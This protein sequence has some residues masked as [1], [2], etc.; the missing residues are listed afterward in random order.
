MSRGW[1][2]EVVGMVDVVWLLL[3][4]LVVAVVVCVEPGGKD[5]AA[6][7]VTGLENGNLDVVRGGEEFLSGGEPGDAGA[8]DDGVATR[9]GALGVGHGG[10]VDGGG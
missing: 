9:P 8:D 5:A 7:S 2:E 1:V 10:G 3:R 6:D 4:M